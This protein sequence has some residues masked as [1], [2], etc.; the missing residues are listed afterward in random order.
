MEALNFSWELPEAAMARDAVSGSF[1]SPSL[2]FGKLRVG[3][4]SVRMTWLKGIA[5]GG[6][7]EEGGKFSRLHGES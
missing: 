4:A 2:P 3:R 6:I 7:F 1:R 5:R